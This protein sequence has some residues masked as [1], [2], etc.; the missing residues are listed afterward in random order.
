MYTFKRNGIKVCKVAL[1]FHYRKF[2]SV[3]RWLVDNSLAKIYDLVKFCLY[4]KE[5]ML[6]NEE[7]VPQHVSNKQCSISALFDVF[8]IYKNSHN[9]KVKPETI[10]SIKSAIC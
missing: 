10:M 8:M 3:A 1:L 4:T 5:L 7:C 6:V 9:F 2:H